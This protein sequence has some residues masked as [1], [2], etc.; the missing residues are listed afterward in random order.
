MRRSRHDH[1][2]IPGLEFAHTVLVLPDSPSPLLTRELVYTGITRAKARLDLYVAI[3]PCWHRP[4][5]KRPSVI[6]IKGE[7]GE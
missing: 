7:V 4:C 2:Q 6:R 1:P 3:A 5:G